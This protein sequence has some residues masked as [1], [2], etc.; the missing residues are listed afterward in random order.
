VNSLLA[1]IY[2]DP[3]HPLLRGNP[4]F[5]LSFIVIII[6][7][8]VILV[9]INRKPPENIDSKENKGMGDNDKKAVPNPN[10]ISN[11]KG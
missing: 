7:F 9:A 3:P 2:G 11:P 4:W 10:D 8:G 5:G 6:V 1:N